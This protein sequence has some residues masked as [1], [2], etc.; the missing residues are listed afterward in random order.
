MRA[1]LREI[2]QRAEFDPKGALTEALGNLDGYE[3]FHNY[4]LVATYIE[5]E[6]IGSIIKPDRPIEAGRFECKIGLV[7]KCGPLAFVDDKTAQFGGISVK[8]GDWV[9]YNP[10]DGWEHFV[11]DY[12][13]IN[14]GVPCR[15]VPD[16][17]IMGRL[18]DPAMVY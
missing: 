15:M 2:A 16:T 6:K 9:M 13:T 3:P 4:V 8:P 17:R 5:P 11:R 7:L 1:S 14:D 18:A 10:A 12:R